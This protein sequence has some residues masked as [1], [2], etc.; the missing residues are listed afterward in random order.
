MRSQAASFRR[1]HAALSRAAAST[2][3]P[4][5]HAELA[6]LRVLRATSEGGGN[7]GEV[8]LRRPA[9]DDRLLGESGAGGGRCPI[10]TA[11]TGDGSLR[12]SRVIRN[13]QLA[14]VCAAGD[15]RPRH[16]AT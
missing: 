13:F 5:A 10:L 15:I 4:V 7:P 6:E 14:S 12:R 2:E 3:N 1:L 16:G 9:C 8:G 11:D